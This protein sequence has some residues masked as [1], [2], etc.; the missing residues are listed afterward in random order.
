M[1]VYRYAALAA[2]A[3]ATLALSACEAVSD[4]ESHPQQAELQAV[5]ADWVDRGLPGVQACIDFHDLA[6]C[7]VSGVAHIETVEP[8][9]VEI[10]MRTASQTKL[11]THALIHEMAEAGVF[12]IEDPARDY[13]D[14]S[15]VEG[16][17]NMDGIEIGHLLNHTSGLANFNS[18]QT[19]FFTDLY[20]DE[21]YGERRW[22]PEEMVAYATEYPPTNAPGERWS[23]SSTG[24]QLLGLIAEQAGRAPLHILYRRYLSEPLGLENTYLEGFETVPGGIADSYA[25]SDERGVRYGL[26]RGDEVHVR[27]DGLINL[28]REHPDNYNAWA[29]AAGGMATTAQDMGRLIEAAF[30]GEVVITPGQQEWIAGAEPDTERVS[31]GG[32]RGISSHAVLRPAAGYSVVIVNTHAYADDI[33]PADAVTRDLLAIV[34]PECSPR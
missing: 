34:C 21:R 19:S 32:S 24:Y 4:E 33:W 16:L 30:K 1:A 12:S 8:L 13:L 2:L 5:L 22:T 11:F 6:W 25:K 26:F 23:Y 31:A 10:P 7:G 29:W 27:E 3:L 14:P 17:P 18:S 9:T 15:V 20:S 28:S